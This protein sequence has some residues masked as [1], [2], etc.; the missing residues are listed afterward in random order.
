MHKVLIQPLVYDNMLGNDI[1]P[2]SIGNEIIKNPRLVFVKSGKFCGVLDFMGTFSKWSMH[3][4][5]V[6]KVA[7]EFNGN[8]I[9]RNW[10][11]F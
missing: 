1:L 7:I 4:L 3:K 10:Y 6:F 11:T 9:F 8:D 2:Y 5:F